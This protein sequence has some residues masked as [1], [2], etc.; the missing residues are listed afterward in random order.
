VICHDCV[1][2]SPF[3]HARHVDMPV[4]LDDQV[5]FLCRNGPDD[6]ACFDVPGGL[7]VG[8]DDQPDGPDDQACSLRPSGPDDR[9]S[10]VVPEWLNE[11][12]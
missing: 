12:G 1:Y 11:P 5:C 6:Q 8:L 4:G 10:F 7:P 2:L 3:Q 9:A